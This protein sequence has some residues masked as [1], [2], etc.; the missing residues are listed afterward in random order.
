MSK[1]SHYETLGLSKGANE[2]EIKKAYRKLALEHHPDKN[3]D[4]DKFREIQ[5]AYE[6]LSDK[7]RREMY[8]MTGQDGEDGGGG[9]GGGGGGMPFPFPFD[10]GAMFGGMGGMFGSGPRGQGRQTQKG[11]K[12]P[13]KIHEMPLSL[14]DFYH[15]KTITIQFER[16]SFCSGCK[17][18]GATEWEACGPCGGRGV[19]QQHVMMGPGMMGVMTGPCQ[20]CSGTGKRIKDVCGDC[21]GNKF[22]KEEKKLEVVI[23]AGARPGHT[24]V[25]PRECSDT[26][27]YMEA[28]DVR[29]ILHEADEDIPVKRCVD[30]KNNLETRVKIRLQ[31][32][33]LGCEA[34]IMGH[35]RQPEGFNVEIPLGV[36]NGECVWIQGDGMPSSPVRGNLCVRVTVE[37]SKEE[38]AALREERDTIRKL[39]TSG[40]S[41]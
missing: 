2:S 3:G 6:V 8:D 35:P 26:H 39:F 31:D 29:I 4:P 11:M 9:G 38:V 36:Q 25:F 5:K 33:L 12:A 28:G 37:A 20:I 7:G 30:D 24:I 17:G 15:G 10:L 27:D 13:P 34:T 16:M 23:P 19:T 18:E 32:S 41:S 1:R 40:R 14:Y 22:K 21:G